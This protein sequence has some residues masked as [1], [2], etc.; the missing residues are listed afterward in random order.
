MEA[1]DLPPNTIANAGIVVKANRFTSLGMG[2][3]YEGALQLDP[4]TNP[5]QLNMHF[6]AGPE[7]GNTNL[8]IHELAGDVWKLCIA[9]EGSERPSAFISTPGTGIALEMIQRV[10]PPAQ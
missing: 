3:V 2:K 4:S 10:K 7:K 8:C 6:D 9:T 5:R 1:Q